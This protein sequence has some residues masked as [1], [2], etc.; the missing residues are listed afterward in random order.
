VLARRAGC[1]VIDDLTEADLSVLGWSGSTT[2]IRSV[3]G[4]LDRVASGAVEY[5]VA[6]DLDGQP[7]AK[8]GIVYEEVAGVAEIM[9][10]VT[11]DELQGL[12]V[13]TALIAAAE[14]RLRRRGV[15]V[16]RVGVEDDNPRARALYERLGYGVIGRRDGS[17][18]TEAPDGTLFEHHTVITE[19]EKDLGL[20]DRTQWEGA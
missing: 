2:H 13:G 19:L 15:P 8:A 20:G 7:V 1:L 16:A 18:E 4:Y 12:G 10:L 14:E 5:L 3:A 6:R 17:W 9:Q 11:R